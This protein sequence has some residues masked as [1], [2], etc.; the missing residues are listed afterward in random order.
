MKSPWLMQEK[1]LRNTSKEY[2]KEAEP[3]KS[4]VTTP[5][6]K[7]LKCWLKLMMTR[8]PNAVAKI[9]MILLN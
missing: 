4:V 3:G 7:W 5:V 8:A 2:A 9:K 6:R 1:I